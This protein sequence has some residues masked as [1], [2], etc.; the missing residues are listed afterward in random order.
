[1]PRYWPSIATLPS[2]SQLPPVLPRPEHHPLR[3]RPFSTGGAQRRPVMAGDQSPQLVR[4][5]EFQA[6]PSQRRPARS[7]SGPASLE[8]HTVS[9]GADATS[10][11]GW[12]LPHGGVPGRQGSWSMAI[13]LRP[14]SKTSQQASMPSCTRGTRMRP[15]PWFLS[16]HPA[17]TLDLRK[18]TETHLQVADG[19]SAQ[20]ATSLRFWRPTLTS[21]SR[22]PKSPPAS[23]LAT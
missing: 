22:M 3:Q 8:H 5:L 1:M 9:I 13:A 12:C 7:G 6:V 15:L 20:V 11:T 18:A 17:P 19:E 21:R 14:I 2:T 23:A 10:I 16:V 4:R